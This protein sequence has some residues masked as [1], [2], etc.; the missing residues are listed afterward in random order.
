MLTLSVMLALLTVTN[1]N[2][3]LFTVIKKLLPF[4]VHIHHSTD[5][6]IFMYIFHYEN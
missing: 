3:C 6:E 5:I 2:N 1:V 4:A